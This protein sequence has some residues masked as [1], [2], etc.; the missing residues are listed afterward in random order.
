MY[1]L[2]DLPAETLLGIYGSCSS[3]NDVLNL[4]QTCRRLYALLP[5]SQ[6]LSVL[7]SV[8]EAQAGPIFDVVQL[9]TVNDVQAAHEIREPSM[10]YHLLRDILLVAQTAQEWQ[11]IYPREKWDEKYADRRLL[12]P[13][14]L[15]A[16]RRAIY[17]L[18]LFS[19]AFHNPNYPRESRLHP[20]RI[21]ERCRLLRAWSTEELAEIEDFRGI[22]RSVLESA[23]LGE[24]DLY[25]E[26][27][28]T[29]GRFHRKPC[30]FP[31]APRPYLNSVTTLKNAFHISNDDRVSL[32]QRLHSMQ[33]LAFRARMYG[34]V[35]DITRFYVLEDLMKLDPEQVLWLQENAYLNL[36][37]P[38]Q[39]GSMGEEWFINNGETFAQSFEMVMADRGEDAQEIRE[40]IARGD[41]GIAMGTGYLQHIQ[42]V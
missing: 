34:R 26:L 39:V 36:Q 3:V 8:A 19:R 32:N 10:S 22:M 27:E 37:V 16:L 4:S 31:L 24:E 28:P 23:I 9:L 12:N 21:K 14:E 17:R 18:W 7:L 42:Q 33:A 1:L 25:W 11:E 15:Y 38:D 35:D 5:S 41:L 29:S 13:E 20:A 6:K 40:R 30:T 2:I